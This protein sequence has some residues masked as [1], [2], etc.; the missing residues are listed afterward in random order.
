MTG[1]NTNKLDKGVKPKMRGRTMRSFVN[2]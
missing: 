2:W 1:V